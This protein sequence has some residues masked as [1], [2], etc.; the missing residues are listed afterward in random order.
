[1]NEQAWKEQAAR[2]AKD[3]IKRIADVSRAIG[4]QANVGAM[5]TAG[6]IISFLDR[7]PDRIQAFLAG[8]EYPL[9]WPVGWHTQGSLTW[10]GVDGKIHTPAEVRRHAL[11][12]KM[13]KGGTE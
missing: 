8:K 4:F 1:M 5:E 6:S 3:I 10:H 2:D 7:N 9:D 13:E 12:K 11:I